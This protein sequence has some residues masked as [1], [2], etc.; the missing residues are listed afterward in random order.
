[1][2][3]KFSLY[4]RRKFS[5]CLQTVSQSTDFQDPLVHRVPVRY[6]RWIR[7]SSMPGRRAECPSDARKLGIELIENHRMMDG[8]RDGINGLYGS[9]VCFTPNWSGFLWVCGFNWSLNSSDECFKFLSFWLETSSKTGS[10]NC[11]GIKRNALI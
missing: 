9:C 6:I 1:M 3:L 7:T 4:L 10:T 11:T 2:T 5:L 8:W